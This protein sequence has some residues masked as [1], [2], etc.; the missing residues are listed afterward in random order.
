MNKRDIHLDLLRKI[1]S[2]PKYTQR[3]LSSEMGVSLGKIN[4][5]LKKL[6]EKGLVKFTNFSQNKNKIVYVYL[7]TPRGIEEKSKLTVSFL[8]RKIYEYELLKK[9]ISEL[10]LEIESEELNIENQ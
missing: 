5:C 8:K 3:K 7:L 2:N 1:E 4:Y 10:K 9:E 6:T